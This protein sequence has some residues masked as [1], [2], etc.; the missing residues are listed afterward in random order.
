MQNIIETSTKELTA[1]E[2]NNFELE[3]VQGI[4]VKWFSDE[5]PL[6]MFMC[7]FELE[8]ETYKSL[9]RD[10][11]RTE[12]SLKQDPRF[13]MTEDDIKSVRN[14]DFTKTESILKV[15]EEKEDKIIKRMSGGNTIEKNKGTETETEEG[16]D[17]DLIK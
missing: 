3:S 14:G 16:L 15:A 13:L 10:E 2:K 6:P 9:Y 11:V 8:K 4:N 7:D 1:N 17:E 12:Q 5:V